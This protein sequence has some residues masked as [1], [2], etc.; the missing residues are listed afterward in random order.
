[1]RIFSKLNLRAIQIKPITNE[2]EFVEARHIIDMLIDADMIED[3]TESKKALD[4]LDAITI[5]A[6]EYE[7]KHYSIPISN[8]V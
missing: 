7:S 1:M 6:S 5:L 4:I 8:P 2:E 3:D